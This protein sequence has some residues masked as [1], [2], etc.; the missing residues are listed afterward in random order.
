MDIWKHG[1]YIDLWS[2]VHF[3]SGALL[4]SLFYK[5]QYGFVLS[6]VLS[7]LL[8]LAWEVFEWIKKIIE[9]SINV[10]MDIIIGVIGFL[11]G[12]YVLIMLHIS[13]EL[14]FY[15]TALGAGALALWGFID[16]QKRG[17]R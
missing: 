1:T 17:Y 7:T 9:P 13:F 5:L 16:F 4:A 3:L 15:P 2:L 6:L 10:G 12:S 14:F 8:L 11:F